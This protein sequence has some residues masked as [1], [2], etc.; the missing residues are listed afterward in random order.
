MQVRTNAW[1]TR[2]AAGAEN[3]LLNKAIA[4]QTPLAMPD[5]LEVANQHSKI[6]TGWLQVRALV[7][8]S[9]MP[10]ELKQALNN[11][12]TG[13]FDGSFAEMRDTLYKKLSHASR[14][15]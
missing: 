6:I 8:H 11:A 10:E 4:L 14:L 9:T 3:I 7:N 12:E 5:I 13:Y 1:V 2:S 15:I